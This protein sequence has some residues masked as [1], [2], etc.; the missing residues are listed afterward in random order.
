MGQFKGNFHAI[1]NLHYN[2]KTDGNFSFLFYPF[3][4][5]DARLFVFWFAT[6]KQFITNKW[7]ARNGIRSK[8]QSQEIPVKCEQNETMGKKLTNNNYGMRKKCEQ[9]KDFEPLYFMA[10]LAGSLSLCRCVC[11]SRLFA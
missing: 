9:S 2:Q 10:T 5:H 3:L 1:F 4:S 8:S 11:V 7:D 6:I